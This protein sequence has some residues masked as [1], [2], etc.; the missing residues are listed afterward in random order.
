M[1]A[2][3]IQDLELLAEAQI[4]LSELAASLIQGPR[5][6]SLPADDHRT[7]ERGL[8]AATRPTLALCL[9]PEFII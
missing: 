1:E 4:H 8:L 9:G 7:Q 6:P 3:E 2:E 5:L